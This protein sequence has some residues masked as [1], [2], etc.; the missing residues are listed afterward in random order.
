MRPGQN[1]Q[2]AGRAPGKL[3]T[4]CP[5]RESWISDVNDL[6]GNSRSRALWAI[7][8]KACPSFS[9]AGFRRIRACTTKGAMGTGEFPRR[10]F[11]RHAP[12]RVLWRRSTGAWACFFWRG[13]IGFGRL[14]TQLQ[15]SVGLAAQPRWG[16]GWADRSHRACAGGSD[17]D[18]VSPPFPIRVIPGG[19]CLH[20]A[21]WALELDFGEPVFRITPCG[22]WT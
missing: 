18:D 7:H 13:N 14:T 5:G 22:L 19:V 16:L 11:G 1:K 8:R 10:D 17:R 4:G 15:Q 3:T 2:D 21:S 12:R 6:A 9:S 20:P